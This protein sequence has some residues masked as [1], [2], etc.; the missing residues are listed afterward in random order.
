R[1]KFGENL[2][3]AQ[4]EAAVRQEM[5]QLSIVAYAMFNRN[6]LWVTESDLNEDLA[7]LLGRDGAVGGDQLTAAELLL[8]RFYFVYVAQAT[9]EHGLL[10]TY[11]FLHATFGE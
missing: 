7:V 8:G 10:K 1:R 4:L 11:E 2:S 3:P 9:V 6:H 5:L